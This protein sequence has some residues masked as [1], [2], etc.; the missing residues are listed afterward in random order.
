MTLVPVLWICASMAA[1]APALRAIMA[2]TEATPMITPRVVRAELTLFRCRAL[3]AMR[4]VFITSMGTLHT[5]RRLDSDL[6]L[7]RRQA[8]ELRSRVA[9]VRY[10]GV[11]H[12]PPV[13][14]EHH[15]LR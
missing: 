2:M 4:S 15:A 8:G 5:R 11:T 14:D 3:N 13:A 9:A 1:R 7:Q 12:H 6:H 10:R